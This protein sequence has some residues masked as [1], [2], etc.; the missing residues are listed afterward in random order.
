MFISFLSMFRATMCPSSGETT[1]FM[2][3]LVTV[4]LYGWLSGM[5]CGMNNKYQVSHKYCC[6]SWWWAHSRLKYVEKI[7]KHTKRK[8]APSWLYLQDYTG[9]QFNKTQKNM[10][11][12]FWW[13]SGNILVILLGSLTQETYTAPKI[14]LGRRKIKNVAHLTPLGKQFHEQPR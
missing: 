3:H 12:I 6:F 7:N 4:T 10:T 11:D 14:N 2:R 13:Y 1:V 5:H 8:C 9:I